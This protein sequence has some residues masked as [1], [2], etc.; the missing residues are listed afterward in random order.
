VETGLKT[1]N[2]TENVKFMKSVNP[3]EAVTVVALEI[4]VF[5]DV[6]PCSMSRRYQHFIGMCFLPLKAM[7]NSGFHQ[8]LAVRLLKYMTL[9]SIMIIANHLKT[10]MNLN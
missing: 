1:K 3:L 8:D 7:R 2:L 6:T 4:T 5:W 9:L 10:K